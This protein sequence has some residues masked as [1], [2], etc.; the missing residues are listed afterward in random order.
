MPYRLFSSGLGA[1]LGP[2]AGWLYAAL[3]SYANDDSSVTFSMSNNAI[4]S[5]T[6]MSARTIGDAKKK[7]R[8]V[9]LIEYSSVP[10]RRDEY[11]LKKPDLER[12]K[13]GER[14]RAKKK[15]RGKMTKEDDPFGWEGLPQIL[16]GTS[17]N[18]AKPYRKIC[19]S[20]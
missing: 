15:P 13:R 6:G 5:D 2:S 17:V 3:C 9:G 18:Y 7:L 12:I 14:P 16:R 4:A 10:G 19:A 20:A 1:K 8:E 11:T